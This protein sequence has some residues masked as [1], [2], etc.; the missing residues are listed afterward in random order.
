VPLRRVEAGHVDQPVRH[1]RA[2]SQFVSGSQL[3][4][5]ECVVAAGQA[6]V[7]CVQAQRWRGAAQHRLLV[8]A[9]GD[10]DLRPL[11]GR[12]SDPAGPVRRRQQTVVRADQRELT[13][14]GE[15]EVVGAAVEALSSRSRSV[16][17]SRYGATVP[18]TATVSPSTPMSLP[19]GLLSLRCPSLVNRL[20]CTMTGMSSTPYSSGR[21]TA[22]ASSSRMN[23]PA[24]PR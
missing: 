9:D 14:V 18:F 3:Q 21:S 19:I 5:V 23:M 1:L 17:T 7:D 8:A 13:V 22:A 11:A 4:D 24:R 12:Q 15:P 6:A 2:G 10:D 16:V 20:S